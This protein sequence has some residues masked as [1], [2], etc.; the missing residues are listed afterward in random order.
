MIKRNGPM[1]DVKNN[2]FAWPLNKGNV[3]FMARKTSINKSTLGSWV[4][5]YRSKIETEMEKEGVIPLSKSSSEKSLEEIRLCHKV[6]WL[7]GTCSHY[8]KRNAK[9]SFLTFR[10]NRLCPRMDPG[11]FSCHVC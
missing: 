11:W 4:K 8:A 6:T 10:G 7:K 5:Q 1:E 2:T 9:K 3:T